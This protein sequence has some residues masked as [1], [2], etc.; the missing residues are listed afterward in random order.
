MPETAM[1]QYG[2]SLSVKYP[3]VELQNTTVR[4]G[5]KTV[6]DAFS[7]SLQQ[8]EKVTITGRSG[9]G[10]STILR[11]ILGFI[12]PTSGAVFIDGEKLSDYSVWKLRSR[13]AYVAQEPD[14]GSGK[15][16]DIIKRPFL[17]R[18]NAHLRDN[19]S[20]LDELFKRFLLSPN[21]M[22]ADSADLSGGEKQRVAL[23]SAILLERKIFLLDEVTSALDSKSKR[24]VVGYFKFRQDI[25]I[26]SILHEPGNEDFADRIIDLDSITPRSEI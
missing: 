7:F 4:F 18:V 12:T 19:M 10:K 11:C 5:D 22:E 6:M 25:S 14:L 21:L 1:K 9:S 24:A 8:G 15:V 3:V 13:I 17:F 20:R 16:R 26:L 2:D 23:I